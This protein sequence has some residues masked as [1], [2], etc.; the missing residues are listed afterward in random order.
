ML[1]LWSAAE[2]C[3]GEWPR[4]VRPSKG[5]GVLLLTILNSSIGHGDWL[6]TMS[7]VLNKTS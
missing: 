6:F 7:I 1:E 4:A 3:K 2:L 5:G